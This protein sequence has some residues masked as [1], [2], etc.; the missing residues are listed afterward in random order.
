MALDGH[1]WL[2]SCLSC[3]TPRERAPGIHWAGSWVD[4]REFCIL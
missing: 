4:P 1:E 2:A 3:F